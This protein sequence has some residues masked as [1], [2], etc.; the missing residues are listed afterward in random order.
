MEAGDNMVT[1]NEIKNFIYDELK[2]VGIKTD[3]VEDVELVESRIL[4][5]LALV[6]IIAGVESLLGQY[7]ITDDIGIEELTTV[8]KM[9]AIAQKIQECHV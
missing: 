5:S 2:K 6:Q 7:I 4:S 1:K 8:N 9:L 3:N